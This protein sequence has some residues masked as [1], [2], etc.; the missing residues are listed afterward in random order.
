MPSIFDRVTGI[1]GGIARGFV[2]GLKSGYFAATSQYRELKVDPR[3]NIVANVIVSG[4]VGLLSS[5]INPF[6]FAVQGIYQGATK[7]LKEISERYFL[8]H[9]SSWSA[10]STFIQ[11][12]KRNKNNNHFIKSLDKISQKSYVSLLSENELIQLNAYIK[13]LPS[14]EKEAYEKKLQL[15]LEAIK[16]KCP[17]SAYEIDEL[18]NPITISGSYTDT[19]KKVNFSST[20]DF[21]YLYTY[22][23]TLQSEKKAIID[24]RNQIDLTNKSN[25][26]LIQNGF[27]AFISDFIRSV[28][29]IFSNT[30]STMKINDMIGGGAS[31]ETQL[32]AESPTLLSSSGNNSPKEIDS[33]YYFSSTNKE[34]SITFTSDEESP[35]TKRQRP[36]G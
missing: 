36:A 13:K 12:E 8:G 7:G 3:T 4:V 34:D 16:E 27:P 14:D 18:D 11:N 33:D 22:A 32:R 29:K 10:S 31:A 35:N 26:I 9:Y 19:G 15:Y 24:P 21:E 2:S 6:V 20:Y 1:F 17:L 25:N 23:A 30:P 28:R 5:I